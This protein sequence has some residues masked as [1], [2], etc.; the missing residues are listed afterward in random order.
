M[1]VCKKVGACPNLVST[2]LY[3]EV[4]PEDCSNKPKSEFD[5]QPKQ[6]T[7]PAPTKPKSNLGRKRKHPESHLLEKSSGMRAM[8]QIHQSKFTH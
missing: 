2:R 8:D 4:C 5:T 1:E 6:P 7:A 3:D